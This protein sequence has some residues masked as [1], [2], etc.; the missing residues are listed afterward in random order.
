MEIMVV[1]VVQMME[2]IGIVQ[3]QVAVVVESVQKKLFML[4]EVPVEVLVLVL[5]EVFYFKLLV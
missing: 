5:V 3:Q 2:V 4:K 1:M